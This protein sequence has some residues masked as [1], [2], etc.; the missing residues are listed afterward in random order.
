[1][2]Y[3]ILAIGRLFWETLT[4]HIFFMCDAISTDIFVCPSVIAT[5][6]SLSVFYLLNDC[7]IRLIE[8]IDA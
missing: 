3:N 1:M 2:D 7:F 8:Y 5:I 4:C 6:S